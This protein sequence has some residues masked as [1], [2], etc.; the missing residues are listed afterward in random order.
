LPIFYSEYQRRLTSSH[1]EKASGPLKRL[2]EHYSLYIISSQSEVVIREVL[3]RCGLLDLFKRVMGEETHKSKVEK[4]KILIDVDGINSEN[5][6]FITDTL[7][8]VKEA[9]LVN[10]RTIAETFGFHDRERLQQGNPFT[11]VDS[12]E[13]I[14]EVIKE[15]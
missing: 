4:F 12:W 3:S 5:T 9:H 13:E 1:L 6:V 11:I 7:G 15:L 2:A 8:D 14:E 10:I